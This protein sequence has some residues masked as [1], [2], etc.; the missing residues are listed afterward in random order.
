M[1]GSKVGLDA[2]DAQGLVATLCSNLLAHTYLG[3]RSL[4]LRRRDL[5]LVRTLQVVSG[6]HACMVARHSPAEP[7]QGYGDFPASFLCRIGKEERETM[8][9]VEVVR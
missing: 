7:Y 8:D 3:R 5:S 6:Q 4:I 2:A 1:R 9:G